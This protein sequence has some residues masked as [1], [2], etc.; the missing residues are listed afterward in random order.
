MMAA[1]RFVGGG[2]LDGA[3]LDM[4]ADAAT[5]VTI[6]R[7]GQSWYAL[8]D[9]EDVYRFIGY[10]REGEIMSRLSRAFSEAARQQQEEIDEALKPKGCGSCGQT[11]GS[12][13]AFAVHYQDGPG[14]RC[15]VG[16]ARGQLVDRDGVLCLPGSD[17]SRR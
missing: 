5:A 8:D 13:G 11:F 4:P 10:G 7:A 9:S 14:S 16:D 2:S 12:A 3:A 1:C 17:V 6:D 15:L